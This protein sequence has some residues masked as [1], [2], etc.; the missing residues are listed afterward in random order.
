M[1]ELGESVPETYSSCGGPLMF[2]G[3]LLNRLTPAPRDYA[4][5]VRVS[6]IDAEEIRRTPR[7]IWRQIFKNIGD[8]TAERLHPFS[9]SF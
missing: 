8:F 1:H 7:N 9:V 6:R 5:L 3:Y 4:V 2:P